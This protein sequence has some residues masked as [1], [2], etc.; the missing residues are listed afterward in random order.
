MNTITEDSGIKMKLPLYC[1][2]SE[3]EILDVCSCSFPVDVDGEPMRKPEWGEKH[4]Q[5]L[6]RRHA[7]E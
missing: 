5:Q 6:R 7:A 4:Q 3:V 1:A 2:R